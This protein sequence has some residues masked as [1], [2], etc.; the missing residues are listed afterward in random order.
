MWV[1]VPLAAVINSK[2]G[3][4]ALVEFKDIQVRDGYIYAIETDL[5]TGE[6]AK[7]KLSTTKEEYYS[8]PQITTVPMKRAL[9]CLQAAIQKHG[10]KLGTK[11]TVAWG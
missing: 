6:S 10:K 7:I 11:Y 3:D 1:Q 8:Q 5:M 4:K 9:W 2:R